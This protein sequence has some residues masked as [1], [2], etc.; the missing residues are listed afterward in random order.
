MAFLLKDL[1][2]QM[3]RKTKIG[4]HATMLNRVLTRLVQDRE[5]AGGFSAWRARS[6]RERVGR[7][8]AGQETGRD[9][10]VRSLRTRPLARRVAVL[11]CSAA[12]LVLAGATAVGQTANSFWRS[13]LGTADDDFAQGRGITS[14]R[15]AL[16]PTPPSDQS[17]QSLDDSASPAAASR[18]PTARP[19]LGSAPATLTTLS[20]R[21]SDGRLPS[22]PAIDVRLPA[23][24]VAPPA[25][26]PPAD[27]G[28]RTTAIR[29][30]GPQGPASVPNGIGQESDPYAASGLRLGTIRVLPSLGL[31][32]GYE[33]Q[34]G[35]HAAAGESLIFGDI[36]P[37]LRLESDWSRHAVTIDARGRGRIGEDTE[38]EE[39][40]RFEARALGRLDVGPTALGSDTT[41]TLQ[42]GATEEVG[43]TLVT[44]LPGDRLLDGIAPGV[45]GDVTPSAIRR[46]A[47]GRST[48]LGSL[49]LDH[50]IGRLDLGLTGE[51]ERSDG[52]DR[53]AA[54]T[55]RLRGRIGFEASQVTPFVEGSVART[56]FCETCAG[57]FDAAGVLAG[58][59]LRDDRRLRGEVALGYETRQAEDDGATT[60][61]LVWRGSL[62]YELT[63]LVTLDL[64]TEATLGDV[65][66]GAQRTL[67][68]GLTHAP[69]RW[70]TLTGGLAVTWEDFE[71]L[72]DTRTVGGTTRA[73]SASL[74]AEYRLNRF[75]SLT[76]DASQQ[77]YKDGVTSE[78]SIVNTVRVGVIL[79]R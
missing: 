57:G 8:A 4:Q 56:R 71:T 70:L 47:N 55:T 43:E 10:G 33:W 21:P 26:A 22:D 54:T 66:D 50:E 17:L 63:P 75:A 59:R 46:D 14:G 6:E 16:A 30:A 5:R 60:G 7:S 64:A 38:L 72:V 45:V 31:Y 44:G 67:S 37:A 24:T 35:D 39:N 20:D 18:P 13:S 40:Y 12:I 15:T 76:A 1:G 65:D 74:G 62:A 52:D 49:A 9:G 3:R 29:G 2:S 34:E 11:Y 23:A 25:V 68:L 58:L 77:R 27:P 36:E 42:L 41:L 51:V 28:G 79:R 48:L 78:V 32:G 19:P 69:R 73:L 61:G 53:E